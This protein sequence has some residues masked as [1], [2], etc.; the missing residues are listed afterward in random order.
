MLKEIL[1]RI[2]S[3]GFFS[4]AFLAR[5][6]KVSEETVT[7]AISELIRMGYLTEEESALFCAT[8]ACAG[9][10]FASFCNKDFVS[11]YQITSKGKLLLGKEIAS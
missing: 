2:T 3:D 1:M 4:A 11:M 8:D 5:E 7:H 9:C 10:A 6:L